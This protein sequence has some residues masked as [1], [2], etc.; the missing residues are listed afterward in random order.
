VTLVREDWVAPTSG[1]PV[2]ALA[3]APGSYVGTGETLKAYK[4]ETDSETSPPYQAPRRP[5]G[6]RPDVQ[7]PQGV[8]RTGTNRPI[9]LTTFPRSKEL[10]RRSSHDERGD[11]GARKNARSL[12][13]GEWP[14]RTS[15]DSQESGW[16]A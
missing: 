5:R 16:R 12:A 3:A 1:V 13:T 11:P 14:V 6:N 10:A 2:V 7:A 4:R 9:G 8:Q 15:S